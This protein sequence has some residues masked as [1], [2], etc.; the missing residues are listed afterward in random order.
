MTRHRPPVGQRGAAAIDFALVSVLFLP[1]CFG[2]I[3]LG[4]MLWVQNTLQTT[5][6]RTARCVGTANTVCSDPRQYAVDQATEFL[7]TGMVSTGDVTVLTDTSCNSA[8][9]TGV[10]VT[11]AHRFWGATLL[12][13]P[14]QSLSISVSSCFPTAA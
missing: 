11:I 10:V 4:I 1:L 13:P 5:A 3:E 8:P 6:T 7:P 9:G 14:F 12:P 2:I